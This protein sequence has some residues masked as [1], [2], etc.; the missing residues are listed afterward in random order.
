MASAWATMIAVATWPLLLQAQAWL[1][2]RRGP[3]VAVMTAGLLVTVLLPF[4]FGVVTVVDNAGRVVDWSKSLSAMP[5]PDFPAWLAALPGVGSRLEAGWRRVA[6][7]SPEEISSLVLPLVRTSSRW[8]VA[9]AGNLGLLLV[10]LLLTV[11]V[12]AILYTKGEEALIGVDRFA[13]RLAGAQGEEALRLAARAIRAVALGVVVTAIVQ[14]GL[15][16]LGLVAA[17]VPF[18]G[19]LVAVA[20]VLSV[21]QVG[22]ALVLVPATIWVYR[23]DGAGWGTAFLVWAILCSVFDNVLRPLM[24][25]RGAD[26]PLLLIFAG[27]IGGLIGFGVIGL[28]VGPV[29]LAVAYTLVAD[30][31]VEGERSDPATPADVL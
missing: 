18:A 2:G 4:F 12:T 5:L 27:V 13:R 6:G 14:S 17:G 11:A 1:G 7:A 28:F 3:A 9:Q 10:Q 31:V 20:F 29:V 16:G 15:V 25:K 23:T 24:I 30:W 21:A 26:L 19:L 8:V 22:P